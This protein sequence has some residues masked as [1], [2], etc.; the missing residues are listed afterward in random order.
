M[1]Q[2]I[3]VALAGAMLALPAEAQQKP[4]LEQALGQTEAL[5]R[6]VQDLEALVKNHLQPASNITTVPSPSIAPHAQAPAA[7]PGTLPQGPATAVPAATAESGFAKWNELV[8][9]SSTLK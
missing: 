4:T 3:I 9:G 6:Q 5:K 1:N 7:S 8:L 2:K